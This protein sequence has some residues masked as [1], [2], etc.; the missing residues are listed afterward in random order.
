MDWGLC[1]DANSL[2]I[3]IADGIEKLV[4]LL[5]ASSIILIKPAPDKTLSDTSGKRVHDAY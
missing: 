3:Y 4:P 2:S 1:P 5:T